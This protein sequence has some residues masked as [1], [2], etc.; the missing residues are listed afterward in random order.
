MWGDFMNNEMAWHIVIGES[1]W[2]SVKLATNSSRVI[3]LK[4]NLSYGPLLDLDT[5]EGQ[6]NRLDWLKEKLSDA[7]H[8]SFEA[9]KQFR[10]IS[11][12]EPVIIWTAD[13]GSEQTGLRYVMYLLENLP[14]DI[15]MLNTT[16]SY[17]KLFGN[18][19]LVKTTELSIDQLKEIYEKFNKRKITEERKA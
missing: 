2:L 14:N 10:D 16:R 3:G 6:E 18:T 1:S 7:D 19:N 5:I 17:K 12:Y 8:Y 11:P 4:D 15:Y 9:L 13:N